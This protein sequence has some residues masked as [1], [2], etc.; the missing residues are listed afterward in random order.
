MPAPC[1]AVAS[2]YSP[3]SAV[4]AVLVMWIVGDVYWG[5]PFG[6]TTKS[7]RAAEIV[8]YLSAF[9]V[10]FAALK[11]RGIKYPRFILYLGAISY[12]LYLTHAIPIYVMTDIF[13]GNRVM[14]GVT[15]IAAAILISACT[16]R[17]IEKPAI[18]AG[19]KAMTRFVP[20]AAQT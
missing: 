6:V 7:Y 12:S 13:G 2:P 16:Y 9:L 5:L 10:F 8:T 4:A 17:L 18:T 3:A 19:R 1:P 11:W 20:Q 15:W 14:T